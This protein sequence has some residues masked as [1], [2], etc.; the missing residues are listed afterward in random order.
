LVLLHNGAAGGAMNRTVRDSLVVAAGLCTSV[1]TTFLLWLSLHFLHFAIYGFSYWFIPIGAV[2][3]GVAAGS[4]YYWA[5]KKLHRKATTLILA[6]LLSMAVSTYFVVQY[7]QYYSMDVN[8]RHVRDFLSF[9]AYLDL[10]IRSQRVGLMMTGLDTGALGVFGYVL[11]L[12]QIGGFAYGGFY[13]F[14]KLRVRAY[15]DKCEAHLEP[16][17][18]DSRYAVT[19]DEMSQLFEALKR[20]CREE[21][22]S[23]ALAYF[24]RWGLAVPPRNCRL[25]T[26]IALCPC[27]KCGGHWV[28]FQGRKLV[29]GDYRNVGN[30]YITGF[31]ATP[32]IAIRARPSSL[33]GSE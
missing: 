10:M 21:K 7:L 9:T 12:V 6:N 31:A 14:S 13:L 25:A 4:G 3:C 11:L 26:D 16:T 32:L 23:E 29:N 5:A 30:W 19:A 2:L 18:V 20:F 17:M 8:G 28:L 22:I 24:A 1:L 15:C 27:A 33:G